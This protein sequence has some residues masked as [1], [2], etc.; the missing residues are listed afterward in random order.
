MKR[1]VPIIVAGLLMLATA[2]HAQ[3]LTGSVIGAVKDESGAAL[4][5]VTAT[6]TSPALPGGPVSVVTNEMG[7]YR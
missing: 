4:P 1:A 5:G 7:E 6:A 2:V 3:V